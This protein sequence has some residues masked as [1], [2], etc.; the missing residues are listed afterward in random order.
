MK[1]EYPF[2]RFPWGAF[3]K[4]L[5]KTV[6]ESWYLPV[7]RSDE[8]KKWSWNTRSSY[9]LGG[10]E[11]LLFHF[12][13]KNTDALNQYLNIA[14]WQGDFVPLSKIL[15]TDEKSK[16]IQQRSISGGLLHFRRKLH[17]I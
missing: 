5:V 2:F 6:K 8:P 7:Y 14:E 10:S 4:N 16:Y 13:K 12:D 9:K 17:W 1:S 3:T 11:I 15:S